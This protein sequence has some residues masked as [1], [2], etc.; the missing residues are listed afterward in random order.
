MGLARDTAKARADVVDRISNDIPRQLLTPNLE[1]PQTANFWPDN[2]TSKNYTDNIRAEAAAAELYTVTEEMLELV[3]HA[4]KS[5]PAQTIERFDLPDQVGWLHLPKPLAIDGDNTLKITDILWTEVTLGKPG[6]DYGTEKNELRGVIFHCFISKWLNDVQFVD[7][8]AKA[9]F[10]SEVPDVIPG[11]SMSAAFGYH[12]WTAPVGT[13]E[14]DV[15]KSMKSI[16][17]GKIVRELPD[18][19]YEIATSNGKLVTAAP[20]PVVQF[21]KSYFHF[22]NSKLASRYDERLPKSSI[23]WLRRLNL[24]VGPVT[25]V[26]LRRTE[27]HGDSTGQTWELTYRY[28][29]KG[30]WRK[31]WYGSGD[32]KYQRSIYIVETIVGPDDGPLVIRDVVNLLA[33]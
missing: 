27:H 26:K 33:R 22:I 9:A 5:L 2:W 30:H 7:P 19:K 3:H 28:I 16:H 21:M 20:D 14:V 10:S 17:D 15:L 12:T 18:N 32:K 23:K 31:Q 4:S 24:P 29:R 1:D 8:H 25:V 13:P 11:V 6:V